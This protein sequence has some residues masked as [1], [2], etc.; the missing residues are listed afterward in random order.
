MSATP[1][2]RAIRG[3]SEP[4]PR[5]SS[6]LHTHTAR[7][8]FPGRWPIRSRLSDSMGTRCAVA[9]TWHRDA[10]HI[11]VRRD[12]D[13]RETTRHDTTRRGWRWH[14]RSAREGLWRGLQAVHRW[15]EARST[16]GA[17]K[18]SWSTRQQNTARF[19]V[20]SERRGPLR[21]S[22]GPGANQRA[23]VATSPRESEKQRRRGE[24]I[25]RDSSPS[26]S[27]ADARPW[28]TQGPGVPPFPPRQCARTRP[29]A[30][31]P[32]P[33]AEGT[34][35]GLWARGARGDRLDEIPF[36]F[37]RFASG[38]GSGAA[39]RST[40]AR[41]AVG[42]GGTAMVRRAWSGHWGC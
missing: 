6:A 3:C 5:S 22:A 35:T 4:A 2:P 36:P 38:P 28:R 1:T 42:R 32:G 31:L 19:E 25:S 15:A 41:V 7:A 8:A 33:R 30:L 14:S 16:S 23:W 26:T 13:R 12:G 39:S 17:V 18:L 10:S 34:R 21:A 9:Q 24:S 37:S 11:S 29:L 27:S 20:E 40:R